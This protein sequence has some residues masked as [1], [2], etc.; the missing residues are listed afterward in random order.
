MS[1]PRRWSS[2]DLALVA[3]FAALI[4]VLGLA[5]SFTVPGNPVPITL[6]TLGVMLAGSLLGWRRGAAAVVVLLAL[7]AA[8]M[9]LLSSGRAGLGV[10]AGASAGYLLAWPVGAAVIGLLVRARWPRY[11]LWWGVLTNVLGGIVVVYA[12]GV[13]VSAAVQGGELLPA[14]V[15][16]AL[17]LPGDL[18]KALI[19]A[20]VTAG[21]RRGY[22]RIAEEP[23][24]RRSR[25]SA[26]VPGAQQPA[27]SGA[28]SR[29]RARR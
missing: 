16:S 21:V 13:P 29:G 18:A 23:T 7:V 24:S 6:Q 12:I 14:L 26:A 27:P 20:V 10:F 8:G 2:R 9:P 1:A 25:R 17:F 11:P 3:T 4:A 28:G 22:P 5:G 19:A 15:Q